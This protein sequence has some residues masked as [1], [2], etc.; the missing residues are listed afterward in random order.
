[1]IHIEHFMIKD[2]DGNCWCGI[3]QNLLDHFIMNPNY[4]FTCQN[5]NIYQKKEEVCCLQCNL[6]NEY[7]DPIWFQKPMGLVKGYQLFGQFII[8]CENDI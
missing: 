8:N 7:N 1:M 4:T 2:S 3:S 5:P 6:P